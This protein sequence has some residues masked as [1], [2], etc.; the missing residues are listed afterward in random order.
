MEKNFLKQC[1]KKLINPKELKSRID[2]LKKTNKTITTLNGSFDILHAGHL[3]IIYEASTLSD[4][5]IVALNSDI[6]IKKYKSK[7]RPIISLSHR[8]QMLS[9]LYFVDYVTYF[10]ETD[11]INLLSIIKPHIHVNGSEYGQ[12]CIES[13]IVEKNGGKIYLVEKV[14]NKK[15]DLSTTQ[16]I[17]KIKLCE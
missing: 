14:K 11:P 12:E 4:I 5:L 15:N 3:Q 6:S 13:K 16:I 10:D 1:Q 8:M 2:C 7:S 9:A 17:Q